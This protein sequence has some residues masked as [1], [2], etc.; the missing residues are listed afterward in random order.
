MVTARAHSQPGGLPL[1]SQNLSLTS[2]CLEPGVPRAET[3]FGDH[4]PAG[5][6]GII[7][8]GEIAPVSQTRVWEGPWVMNIRC[9]QHSEEMWLCSWE[10][11]QLGPRGCWLWSPG[12]PL[13][14]LRGVD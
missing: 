10:D 2:D 1:G 7:L 12:P 3:C 9:G 4:R 14:L 13:A 5:L 6:V 8:E 11:L